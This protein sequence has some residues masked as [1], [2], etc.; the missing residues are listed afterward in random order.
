ME[1]ETSKESYLIRDILQGQEQIKLFDLY[2]PSREFDSIIISDYPGIIQGHQHEVK[3][4]SNEKIF[5]FYDLIPAD[6]WRFLQPYRNRFEF[7]V[8]DKQG[9]EIEIHIPEEGIHEWDYSDY[10]GFN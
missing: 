2:T 10:S 5:S 9:N 6:L 8:Y 7:G 1:S 3:R 4:N